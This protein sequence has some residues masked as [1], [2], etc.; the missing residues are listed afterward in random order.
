MNHIKPLLDLRRDLALVQN[1]VRYLGG[2]FG[3][4]VKE[5]A[6]L[7][8]A[9]AFPDLYEIAM[10]NLAIKVIYDGLNRLPSV[11]CERVFTPAPDFEDL[12]E[13]K[14]VPLYTLES[15]IPLSEVDILGVSIGYE[16]GITGLLSILKSGGIPLET[17]A[18]GDHDPIVLAGGCGVT[19]PAPFSRFIDAFFIGEAEA[20]L[21]E[22][23]E[24]LSIMKRSGASRSA[25]LERIEAHPAVWTAHK[26][27]RRIGQEACARRAV[28]S[29]FGTNDYRAVCFP[30]PNMRIVQDHGI[31][32][33]MR[34]CPNGCRFC[35]AGS[36]YRPQRMK[37]IGRILADVDYLV[38]AGGY[39]EVSLMSLS[40]GDYEGIA[41]VLNALS[42]KYGER[43]VSFQLPSLKVNSFTL[44]LLEKMA[45]VRKSGLTFAVE[46]PV[47]AWQLSLNKEVYRD[48]IIDIMNKAKRHGWSKAKFYF[49]IGLPVER[50]GQRE[51]EEIVN[52]LLDIQDRTR[53][54]CT[55]NIGTFIPKPHTAYQWSRQ[56]SMEEA[57]RKLDYIHRTLPRGRFKVSTHR[58]LNSFLEAMM[59]RGDERVGS[60]IL[61]AF[62]RGAR[63]DAWE[64]WAKP[65]VWKAAIAEA[66]WN[67]EA[68]TIRERSLDEK[69]PWDGVSL[70]VSKA[71]LKKEMARSDSQ[72]L[73]KRCEVDC[74]EPC[75]V[76]GKA[77]SIVT[78]PETDTLLAA[79]AVTNEYGSVK[80]GEAFIPGKSVPIKRNGDSD[81]RVYISFAKNDEAAFIPHLGLLEIWHKAFQRS[82]LPVVFTEGFN[83]MP[84]FEIAQ[85]LS[86]GVFSNDEI[87][88]F[89]LSEGVAEPELLERLSQVLPRAITINRVIAHPLSMKTKREPLSKY[90][91]G[92]TYEYSFYEKC[93]YEAVTADER[94]RLFVESH[95][96][97][98]VVVEKV[99][100]K[101]DSPDSDEAHLRVTVPF[102]LDRPI[103]DLIAEIRGKTIY[104]VMEIRKI[105]SLAVGKN[106]KA[107]DFFEHFAEVADMHR[108][109]L[110]AE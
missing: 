18:R 43:N 40:S 34:G 95:G 41:G 71:W 97:D 2:E 107:R 13:R 31:V 58:P 69:L 45:E 11:R 25:L 3:Q 51:E 86:L 5:S 89:M 110:K 44:P 21:F 14:G 26:D 101:S 65:D 38:N 91:W 54:Q 28:W 66:P 75:G 16:P 79:G 6:D 77:V 72:E 29:A 92:S 81:W 12:L 52:F 35:H 9:L 68:E 17:T 47:D 24:E 100:A 109:L 102:S 106:G 104:E 103:R 19:N 50:G 49:M 88:S 98:G 60:I 108:Q 94:F 7:T 36:Y 84:R 46:T 78:I 76:C 57:D 73:T 87:A 48:H 70:G 4:I 56:L 105:A 62:S 42:A 27:S 85:S 99:A 1:P 83:P 33:I 96:A 23:V 15:S 22:L 74:S 93:D 64:D 37:G 67:V 20:G 10:S 30:V 63:L 90:L 80:T 53:M 8:F 82:G 59:T 61:E 32:E 39:R 55:A